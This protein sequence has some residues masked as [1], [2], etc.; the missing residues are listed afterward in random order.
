MYPPWRQSNKHQVKLD[1]A[2]LLFH[3][4]EDHFPGTG[5]IS[6]DMVTDAGPRP[7]GYDPLPGRTGRLDA[8]AMALRLRDV[9]HVRWERHLPDPVRHLQQGH[10]EGAASL[11]QLQ[12]RTQ[13]EKVAQCQPLLRRERQ[14]RRRP[15]TR[16][17]MVQLLR[18]VKPPVYI[19]SF[20]LRAQQKL[21]PDNNME[22]TANPPRLLLC[23]LP[24]KMKFSTQLSANLLL[25]SKPS[26]PSFLAF[27][28]RCRLPISPRLLSSQHI[29]RALFYK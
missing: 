11:S 27:S 5:C 9:V 13:S 23:A 15:T 6:V 29:L 18:S 3:R 26:S 1:F 17:Q 21:Q 4:N 10:P 24:S 14:R 8:A 16:L 12:R 28:T 19:T 20:D 25:P 7:T 22:S 2:S